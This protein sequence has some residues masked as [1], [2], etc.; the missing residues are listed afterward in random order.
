MT[1]QRNIL[2]LILALVLTTSLAVCRCGV[3]THAET[4]VSDIAGWV[5]DR[6]DHVV[7][8]PYHC[9]WSPECI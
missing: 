5:K 7:K 8:K 1:K 2:A 9:P 3:L 4:A 6:I